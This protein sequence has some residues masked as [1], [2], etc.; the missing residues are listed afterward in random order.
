MASKDDKYI[1][2]KYAIAN[3]RFKKLKNKVL[4]TSDSGKWIALS[5]KD[6]NSLKSEK[7]KL[8]SNL[9]NALEGKGIILT[10]KSFDKAVDDFRQKNSFLFQGT[11]LHIVVVTLRCN[12]KCS[13]CHASSK[14]VNA[15][16]Y[17]MSKRTAKK[18]VDFIFQSPSDKIAI[19]FQGGEP[20]LNF[21]VVKFIVDY[22]NKINKAHCK[23]L[24]FDLVTNLSLMNEKVLA[25]FIKNKIGV[26]T[27]LDGPEKIHNFNRKFISGKG[28]YA[29]T[30]KWIKETNR[31][32]KNKKVNALV[33][34]TKNQL[35]H[36]KII[37]DEYCKK[38]IEIIHLRPLN[39]LGYAKDAWED[40]GY[41]SDEFINFWKKAVD[42]I[43]ELNKKGKNIKERTVLIMLHK[44]LLNSDPGYLDLRSPCGAAI[45]QLVY[46]YNGDIYSC[47]EGRMIGDD[48]F[49]LG[50]ASKNNYRK[51]LTSTQTCSIITAS[52]NDSF[53][54]NNCVY[55][56][57]CGL[58]PVCSYA[59][60]GSIISKVPETSRC[61]ILKAQ[62]D[63]VFDKMVYDKRAKE[64]F[65]NWIKTK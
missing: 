27:S 57:Y 17:D 22:A 46:H 16:K 11:S 3:Y 59:E 45:G 48:L 21:G 39:N 53:I 35:K 38:G 54:C 40:I 4:V 65:L 58:C 34:V 61:K 62:F 50:N 63:Y 55:K 44:I 42:Y 7:I 31:R 60:H 24:R 10:E 43:L 41:S 49:K 28:S 20:L 30:A 2:G 1:K 15:K 5:K 64:V 25:Y 9:F 36:S 37:A 56:P 18:V 26:C 14:P 29:Q 33:T 12:M 6:F 47:D 8:N 19:E 52:V 13:Y 32:L 23:E 51:V